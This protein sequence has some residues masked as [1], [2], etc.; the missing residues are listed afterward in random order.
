[1][2]INSDL[3]HTSRIRIHF[4]SLDNTHHPLAHAHNK[5]VEIPSLPIFVEEEVAGY[6]IQIMDDVVGKDLRR[7]AP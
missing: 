6:I 3:D 2:G 7:A 5:D 1:M 4:R